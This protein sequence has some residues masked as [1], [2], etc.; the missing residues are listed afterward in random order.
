VYSFLRFRHFEIPLPKIAV[1][2]HVFDGLDHL[3]M[4]SLWRR[5]KKA[6]PPCVHQLQVSSEDPR[7]TEVKDL[8]NNGISPASVAEGN[9]DGVNVLTQ[10]STSKEQCQTC[11]KEQLA[12]RLYRIKLIVGL[13]FPFALQALD[14]TIIAS[15]L[16]W[17]A[18]DFRRF[19]FEDI[20][21][22]F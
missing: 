22:T 12:A 15:A 13:F 19:T 20:R 9:Q 5:K 3:I 14:V 16:P 21:D 2:F 17:I 4:F 18:S 10:V 8:A 11:R 7:G 6:P 1:R